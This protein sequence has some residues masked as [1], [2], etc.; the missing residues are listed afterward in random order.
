MQAG[1]GQKI[2]ITLIDFTNDKAAP[3]ETDTNVCKVYAT[4]KEGN[5]AVTHTVCGGR[6]QKVVPVFMS[7]SNVVE[8]RIIS[9]LKHINN[10]E[11]QFLLK[12]KGIGTSI[13]KIITFPKTA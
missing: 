7:V 6:G 4:I 3:Q 1:I 2:N 10:Y 5:G 12:Y 8:I 9:K 13:C 11:G